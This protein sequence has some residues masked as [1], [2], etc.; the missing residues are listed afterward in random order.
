MNPAR[1]VASEIQNER[2]SQVLPLLRKADGQT[3]EPAHGHADI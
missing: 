2:G 3:N 1:V